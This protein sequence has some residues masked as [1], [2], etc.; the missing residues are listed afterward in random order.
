MAAP[1]AAIIL[2]FIELL[3]GRKLFWIFVAIGGFLVGW[4][5]VPDIVPDMATWLR[6]V[7]GLVAGVIFALLSIPF[8]RVMVAIAGFFVIGGVL[9]TVLRIFGLDIASSSTG[10]W[11]AFV[12]GGLI[13]A[14]LLFLALD[15]A[16]ITLTS[17]A[18]AG[19]VS[20]GTVN[21]APDN[22]YG[23]RRWCS[24]SWRFWVSPCR[25][26]PLL[27]SPPADRLDY[28][29]AKNRRRDTAVGWALTP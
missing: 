24:W 7:I 23:R 22:P 14:M 29:A 10:Y 2:G 18:G 9:V 11:V 21:L 6:I 4:V 3:L 19:S 20:G 15:W 16:L 17:L 28:V 12:I 26:A 1:I 27:P 8:T 13:G 25:R 5:L